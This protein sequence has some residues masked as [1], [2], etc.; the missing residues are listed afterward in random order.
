MY[1]PAHLGQL[2]LNTPA[3]QFE[4]NCF[5]SMTMTLEFLEDN[6]RVKVKAEGGKNEICAEVLLFGNTNIC[7]FETIFF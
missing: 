4:G 6:A 1:F 7:H 2:N 3:I 5:H